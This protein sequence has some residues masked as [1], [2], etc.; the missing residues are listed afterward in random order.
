LRFNHLRKESAHLSGLPFLS[1]AAVTVIDGENRSAFHE[2][3][4]KAL[5]GWR[6][7]RAVMN[8]TNEAAT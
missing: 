5:S 6:R 1:W 3:R 8:R 4:E 2:A 7:K